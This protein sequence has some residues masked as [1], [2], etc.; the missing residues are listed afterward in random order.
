MSFSRFLRLRWLLLA[1]AFP[2]FVLWLVWPVETYD[3]Y[4]PTYLAVTEKPKSEFLGVVKVK[5]IPNPWDAAHY[6][7]EETRP[8][9]RK[10]KVPDSKVKVYW[11]THTGSSLPG[12]LY[13]RRNNL[14]WK[15][16]PADKIGELSRGDEVWVATVEDLASKT[17]HIFTTG[18]LES[19]QIEIRK[20][21][22]WRLFFEA[23]YKNLR[24]RIRKLF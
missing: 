7:E 23:P 12:D 6:I 18:T 3:G 1:I 13:F 16:A 10:F 8:L 11:S 14:V 2:L 15:I 5:K 4:A 17:D 19:S 22:R 24:E 20:V 9:F 21:M